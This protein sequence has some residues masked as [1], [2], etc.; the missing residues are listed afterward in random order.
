MLLTKYFLVLETEA[1]LLFLC[2]TQVE[3]DIA[4]IVTLTISLALKL[5]YYRIWLAGALIHWSSLHLANRTFPLTRYT[6]IKFRYFYVEALFRCCLLPPKVTVIVNP[7]ILW[8]HIRTA[9]HSQ[10]FDVGRLIFQHLLRWLFVSFFT[11]DCCKGFPLAFLWLRW[12]HC[13]TKLETQSTFN[14]H[15][16][17][18]KC[19]AIVAFKVFIYV[20]FF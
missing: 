16:I 9:Y 18:S 4:S 6:D 2:T 12:F 14:K 15:T 5:F 3:V 10:S 13:T 7:G 11:D 19:F 8:F 1:V 17:A 20:V